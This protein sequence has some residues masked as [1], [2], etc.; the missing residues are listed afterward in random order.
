MVWPR[1]RRP[2]R[3][4]APP[5][6]W[7]GHKT[8]AGLRV[9]SLVVYR[10]EGWRAAREGRGAVRASG[11]VDR[12]RLGVAAAGTPRAQVGGRVNWGQQAAPAALAA[13][14]RRLLI[15]EI[16]DS[17]R[18]RRTRPAIARSGKSRRHLPPRSHP[19]G[20]ASS[21]TRPRRG[22]EDS[23]RQPGTLTA[24]ASHRESMPMAARDDPSPTR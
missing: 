16:A 4:A 17:R 18:G 7:A 1:Q 21:M 14:R 12:R 6:A 11:R 5:P 22:S 9:T 13:S 20:A 23:S 3:A 24:P 2:D 8:Q 15:D 19:A 10:H